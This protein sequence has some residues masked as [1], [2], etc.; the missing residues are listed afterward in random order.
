MRGTIMTEPRTLTCGG[1]GGEEFNIRFNYE[2]ETWA[3]CADCG[4][5]TRALDDIPGAR[6]K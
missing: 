4:R 3:V 2:G 1:C 5:R 6:K